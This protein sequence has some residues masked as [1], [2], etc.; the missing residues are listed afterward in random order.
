M[1]HRASDGVTSATL[2]NVCK[3]PPGPVPVPYPNVSLSKDLAEGST[4]V[5]ADGGNMISL[6]GSTFSKSTGDEPGVAGGVTSSTN[7]KE[8]KWILYSFD[9]MI[10]GRNVCRLTDKMTCNHE[11]S[12]CLSG[13]LQP[14]PMN[15]PPTDPVCA[16]L[17][18]AI[19]AAIW[20]VRTVS[21]MGL[22][23]LAK[24][25]EE[26]AVN[27]G[28]W[29]PAQNATHA[30]AYDEQARGVK[31]KVD[32][33]DRKNCND[34]GGGG[35]P[36]VAREYV[37]QRPVLGSGVLT[38]VFSSAMT[39]ATATSTVT[40]ANVATA[41]GGAAVTVGVGYLIYRGIRMIPSLFPPLWW[42]IPEN[43]AI[44]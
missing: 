39:A 22:Q 18:A 2:P 29:T 41:A 21:G 15:Q 4:T 13:T 33:W 40:A 42:T 30:K 17:Y 12:A 36:Q 3:T 34:K 16:A 6:S 7:M 27:R 32:E 11:N 14:N 8:A 31:K 37:T 44:P 35:L 1:S 20:T 10:E 19:Q 24:R 38:P 28:G 5:T 23:G 26:A 43:L 9:V 25:W